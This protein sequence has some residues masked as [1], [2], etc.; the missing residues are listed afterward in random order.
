MS[1]RHEIPTSRFEIR[2]GVVTRGVTFDRNRREEFPGVVAVA[3]EV[4]DL[5]IEGFRRTARV[6]HSVAHVALWGGRGMVAV[7]HLPRMGDEV[8]TVIEETRIGRRHLLWT[9]GWLH[10]LEKAEGSRLG[11]VMG[12]EGEKAWIRLVPCGEAAVAFRSGMQCNYVAEAYA[13]SVDTMLEKGMV[14]TF[15]PLVPDLDSLQPLARIVDVAN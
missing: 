2:K 12:V 9:H 10:G 5:K 15:E 7:R 11:N 8:Q 1:S 14:V 4:F 6:A 13:E 3:D